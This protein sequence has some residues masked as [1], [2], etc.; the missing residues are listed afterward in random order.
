[1]KPNRYGVSIGKDSPSS[2]KKIDAAVCAVGARMVRR[3]YLASKPKK[4]RSGVVM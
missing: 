2:P 3:L 4:K 1:M